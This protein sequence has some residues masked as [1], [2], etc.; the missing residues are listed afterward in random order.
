MSA[1]KYFFQNNDIRAV[2]NLLCY[3][4]EYPHLLT[5]TQKITRLY[6]YITTYPAAYSEEKSSGPTDKTGAIPKTT[7]ATFSNTDSLSK[8]SSTSPKAQPSSDRPSKDCKKE[9]ELASTLPC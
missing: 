7:I 4:T 6:R 2:L 8:P 5:S 9:Y 1:A 3:T